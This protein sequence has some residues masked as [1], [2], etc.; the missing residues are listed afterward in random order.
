M[1]IDSENAWRDSFHVGKKC[2]FFVDGKLLYPTVLLCPPV[3][4]VI[5]VGYV[6]PI[7]FGA[8][9]TNGNMRQDENMRQDVRRYLSFSLIFVAK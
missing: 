6:R 1:F 2:F 9:I 4:V 3:F 8:S 5:S 7:T